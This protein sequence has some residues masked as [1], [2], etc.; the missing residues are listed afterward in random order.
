MNI[1]H[2]STTRPR[3]SPKRLA[4]AFVAGLA[5]AAA[6][7]VSS[8][9]ATYLLRPAKTSGMSGYGWT[10]NPS[11]SSSASVL[12]KAV[13]QPAAP[14]T[15]SFVTATNSSYYWW[16]M[17]ALGLQVAAPPSFNSGESVTSATAWVYLKTGT[18]QSLNLKLARGFEPL[19]NVT[20]PSGKPAGWYSV[21]TQQPLTSSDLTQLTIWLQ[22]QGPASASNTSV[23]ASYIE[24]DTNLPAPTGTSR[25]VD[26]PSQPTS[27]TTTPSSSGSGSSPD[28]GAHAVSIATQTVTVSANQKAVPVDLSCAA[29]TPGGCKGILVLRVLSPTA[30]ASASAVGHPYA[31]AARCARG[32]RVLGKQNF[33]IAAGHRQRVNVHLAHSASHLLHGRKRV[34]AQALVI[35][36][37]SAG[38]TQTTKTT[39]T[40]SQ[41]GSSG[42][43]HGPGAQTTGSSATPHGAD[44]QSSSPSQTHASDTHSPSSDDL[45]SGSPTHRS[46]HPGD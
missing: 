27:S 43:P 46:H 25:P 15:G 40:L 1:V 2:T 7:P 33:T 11:A 41:P 12:S 28:T 31:I 29:G 8:Q 32:C 42:P 3:R 4:W 14:D 19:A 30:T 23:Y 10:T 45:R 20:I 39:L 18:F 6:L 22:S 26:Q 13:T 37:E 38:G 9:A 16:W 17:N 35:T 36:H 34:T 21:S 24:L 44:T 5:V